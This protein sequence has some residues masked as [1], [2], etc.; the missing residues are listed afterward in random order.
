M[1]KKQIFLLCIALLLLIGVIWLIWGNVTVGLITYSV[2]EDN[3]PPAFDGYRIAHVSDLHNSSLWKQTIARLKEA[4]PDII[5]ITGDIIDCK[6]TD[7]KIAL[8]FAEEAVKIAPCYY[9]TGNHEINV[10]GKIREEL[11]NGLEDLGVT[12]LN[13]EEVVL[14]HNEA[15]IALAGHK[16]GKG[17]YVG[18]LTD[19]DGY[20]ILL[21][22]RPECFTDY[23]AGEYDLVLAGHAHGGQ[24]RLPF[25]GGLYA[26]GQGILPD[27]DSG[28]HRE[29]RT[30]MVVSRGI[31]NSS[32]PIRFNNRPEVILLILECQ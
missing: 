28:I 11:L 32:F 14:H 2:T 12:V 9:I 25:V 4:E 29:G 7:V 13:D 8:S 19:F 15:Q 27:Y 18:E 10:S 3:L 24:F 23:V 22:H 31:G 5:C 26:P 16:W 17:D 21:S 30:D 1:K 6:K 20:R